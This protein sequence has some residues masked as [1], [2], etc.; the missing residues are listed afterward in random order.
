MPVL[1]EWEISLNVDDVLQAEGADPQAIRL[2]RPSLVTATEAAIQRGLPMLEPRVLYEKFAVNRLVHDRLELQLNHHSVRKAFLSGEL[3]TR[4]LGRAQEVVVMVAT[5]GRQLDEMVSS[6]F[7]VD[8]V[9]AVALDGVGSAAVEKLAILACNHFESE[10]NANGLNTTIP[11][12]PGMV[13]WPVDQGQPEIFSLLDSEQID[14]DLTESCMMSP[15]KSL[16]MVLGIG[17]DVSPLGT[18]CDFCSLKGVCRYQN[19]YAS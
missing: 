10:V 18:S 6:L 16:S 5:I 17:R 15:N 4:H 9:V 3:V 12:N 2:R 11:L 19:H 1:S 8:P 14:V 13:G 7:K